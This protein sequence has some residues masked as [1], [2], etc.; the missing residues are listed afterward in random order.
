MYDIV[1]IIHLRICKQFDLS[2]CS[3]YVDSVSVGR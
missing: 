2:S 1:P 3:M